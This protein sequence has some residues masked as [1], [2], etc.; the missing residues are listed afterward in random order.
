LIKHKT[1]E[2]LLSYHSKGLHSNEHKRV[3]LNNPGLIEA[4][5]ETFAEIT[6]IE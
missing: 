4:E 3:L 1:G 6:V 5:V 2:E